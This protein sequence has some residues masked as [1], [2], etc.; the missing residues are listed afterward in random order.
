M[1]KKEW[2]EKWLKDHKAKRYG[3]KV[4][5]DRAMI[6]DIKINFFG[7]YYIEISPIKVTH[8]IGAGAG[9]GIKIDFID[10]N[11]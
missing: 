5:D 3:D 8:N 4:F 6:T 2:L 11:E 9:M 10:Y 7:A 1:T